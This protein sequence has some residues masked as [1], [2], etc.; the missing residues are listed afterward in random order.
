MEHSRDDPPTVRGDVRLEVAMG[1]LTARAAREYDRAISLFTEDAV[2]H[3]PVEGARRG[4]G[5]IREALVAAERDTDRV[6]SR[7]E[8]IAVRRDRVVAVVVNRGERE[9]RE[10]DSQ[11][12]LRFGFRG[13][14][15]AEVEIAVDDPDAVAA[16]WA[17]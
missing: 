1:F 3:S 14:R 17:D 4:R 15:I 10:L 13:D 5:A 6:R 12:A 16:F 8:R 7:V 11:Q 9:G 2:W